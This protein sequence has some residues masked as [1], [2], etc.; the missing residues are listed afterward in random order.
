MGNI[1]LNGKKIRFLV[2]DAMH[3]I[4]DNDFDFNPLVTMGNP[5]LHLKF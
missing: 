1:E 2:S 5:A 4:W 3:N